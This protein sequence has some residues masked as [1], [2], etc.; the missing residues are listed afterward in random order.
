MQKLIKLNDYSIRVTDDDYISLTD[1]VKKFPN[2]NILGWLRSKTTL[3]YIYA[4]EK[5]YNPKFNGA[6]FS[7]LREKSNQV[8]FSQLKKL[9]IISIRSLSGR[10]GDTKAHKDIAFEFAMWLDVDFKLW[11]VQE[12][13]RMKTQEIQEQANTNALK[14]IRKEVS[15]EYGAMLKTLKDMRTFNDK[16]TMHYHYT[17]EANM[18]NKL[19]CGMTSKECIEKHGDIPRNVFKDKLVFF[20]ELELM[21]NALIK[22]GWSFEDRK[23]RLREW[24]VLLPAIAEKNSKLIGV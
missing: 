7:M 2:K 13:Q 11:V 12:F 8:S 21:N 6:E 9:N 20:H 15:I 22:L 19:I 24:I 10:Y 16:D 18:L 1:M 14:L 3:D 17:N 4:F 5:R 23:N